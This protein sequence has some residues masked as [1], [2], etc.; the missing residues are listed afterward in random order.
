[1]LAFRAIVRPQ[2]AEELCLALASLTGIH[3]LAAWESL[4]S[5]RHLEG[6]ELD[7][8]VESELDILPKVVVAG[9][10]ESERRDALIQAVIRHARTG[11]DGDGKLYL[12]PVTHWCELS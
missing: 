2:R 8:D 3:D 7:E 4:G 12:L 1:M 6:V 10:V 9:Y 11:G 5:G